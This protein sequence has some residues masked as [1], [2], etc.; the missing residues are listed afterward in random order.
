MLGLLLKA[1]YV[2]EGGHGS[3]AMIFYCP[4]FEGDLHHGY[5]SANNKWPP[6]SE[7]T[8]CTYSTRPSTN[9]PNPASP[10]SWA[11]DGVCWSTGSGGANDPFY[12]LRVVNGKTD[13]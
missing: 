1:G 10:S 8:R 11:T 6:S 5:N 7:T 9:N 13:G 3:S 2:K 4:S 12:P